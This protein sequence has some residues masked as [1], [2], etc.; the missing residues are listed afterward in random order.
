MA[1]WAELDALSAVREALPR[2]VGVARLELDPASSDVAYP[3]RDPVR[4][5]VHW[6]GSC[7]PPLGLLSRADLR[8][9]S[10]GLSRA[11]EHIQGDAESLRE[12][13]LCGGEELQMAIK[14][15]SLG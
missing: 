4:R 12:V 5:H 3:R 13:H 9:H 15:R 11:R 10:T 1:T 2:C 7:M 6:F 14:S 8:P